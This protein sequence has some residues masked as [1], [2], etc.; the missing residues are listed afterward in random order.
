MLLYNKPKYLKTL[1]NTDLLY[2]KENTKIDQEYI[3]QNIKDE[4]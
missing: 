3:I 1:L 4:F 2:I